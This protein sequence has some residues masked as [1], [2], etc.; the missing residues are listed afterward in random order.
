VRALLA[1]QSG[2]P[3]EVRYALHHLVKISH[4]R[5]D[6]YMFDQFP[7]LAEALLDQVLKVSSLFYNVKWRV[8][9]EEGHSFDTDTLD[10]LRGTKDLLKKIRSHSLV[11]ITDGL[12]TEEFSTMMSN[13][14]EAGL[15]LRNMVMLEQNAHYVARISLTR[16]F[17]AIALNLPPRAVVVELQHYALEIA[18]QITKFFILRAD[19]PLYVSLLAQLESDDRGAIITSLRALSRISMNL[20]AHN[21]LPEV[22]VKS[23]MRICD[24]LLVEDEE[25]RSACLDFLYQFTA[26]TENVELL[27]QSIN[28]EVLVSQLVRILMFGATLE[29]KRERSRS[30]VKP[31]SAAVTPPKLSTSIVEQLCQIPDERE[32]SA[33]W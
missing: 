30:T 3:A 21:R 18:E 11:P 33:A 10:A 27:L 29:E 7:G 6:K 22:P 12:Q 26:V 20:D 23:L 25:L 28:V 4:E 17:V 8:S 13:V 15:V 9:Y 31:T 24:W 5:G 14:N 19:D 1:L 2:Q 16:D 32:Q